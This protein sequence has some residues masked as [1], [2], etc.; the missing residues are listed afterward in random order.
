MELKPVDTRVFECAECGCSV[1][2]KPDV[3][4]TYD[5]NAWFDK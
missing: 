5:E 1:S 3:Y 2:T 4:F